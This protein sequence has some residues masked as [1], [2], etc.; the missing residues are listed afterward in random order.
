MVRPR[1]IRLFLLTLLPTLVVLYP[2]LFLGETYFLRDP[3]FIFHPWRSFA[4]QNLQAGEMPLWNPYSYSGMPFLANLQSSLFYPFSLIFWFFKFPHAQNIYQCFHLWGIGLLAFLSGRALSFSRAGSCWLAIGFFMNGVLIGHFEF[5]SVL[6]AL[7]WIP[8]F[9]IFHRSVWLLGLAVVFS[10]FSGYPAV[11]LLGGALL[12]LPFFRVKLRMAQAAAIALGLTAVQVLPFLELWRNSVRAAGLPFGEATA[13]SLPPLQILGLATALITRPSLAAM[14]PAAL[15]VGERYHWE[16]CHWIGILTVILAFGLSHPRRRALIFWASLA[17]LLS[18]GKYAPQFY[19]FSE[20]FKILNF[21]RSS[22]LLMLVPVVIILYLSGRNAG[23]LKLNF[24]VALLVWTTME[25]CFYS[26]GA[27]PTLS[28][29]YFI[30][31]GPIT[32]WLQEQKAHSSIFRFAHTPQTLITPE[33]RARNLM[34]GWSIFLDRLAHTTSLP[35]RLSNAHGSGDPLELAA[36]WRFYLRGFSV[37]DAR[38]ANPALNQMNI[39]YL[40]SKSPIDDPAY[41]LVHESHI[42]V[43]ENLKVWPRAFIADGQDEPKEKAAILSYGHEKVVIQTDGKGRLVLLDPFYPGWEAWAGGKRLPVEMALGLFR[44]VR[45]EGEQ[46]GKVMF[47]FR[48]KSFLLGAAVSLSALFGILL[49][50][51]RRLPSRVAGE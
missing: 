13:G 30:Q 37:E 11:T 36:H 19:L 2:M 27:H 16:Y 41:R 3:T 7:L 45:L 29:L 42:R 46:D 38:S 15:P 14:D 43:Y 39:R 12:L 32:R 26:F 50:W 47:V 35:Y 1:D 21:I 25:I 51:T 33:I 24:R 20:T 49:W 44:K 10:I 31:K 48:S 18:F 28:S 4:S 34:E 8:A 9:F 40:L 22:H 5:L 23:V 17:S 6:G